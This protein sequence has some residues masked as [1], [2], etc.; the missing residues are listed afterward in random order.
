MKYNKNM[1]NTENINQSQTQINIQTLSEIELK[2][3]AFDIQNAFTIAQNNATIINNE[4]KR[5]LELQQ[6]NNGQRPVV[7]S[8]NNIDLVN[9]TIK[10]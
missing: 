3:L 1:E 10:E 9:N 7:G 5:R 4:F 2:A 8:F 6:N